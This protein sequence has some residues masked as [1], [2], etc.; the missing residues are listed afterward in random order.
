MPES[1]SRAPHLV[2]VLGG[3]GRATKERRT[4]RNHGESRAQHMESLWGKIRAA[5]KTSCQN[6]LNMSTRTGTW[7]QASQRTTMTGKTTQAVMKRSKT[8]EARKAV[9][10]DGMLGQQK[11]GCQAIKNR[12]TKTVN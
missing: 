7:D 5:T 3:D 12:V 1:K 2:L 4:G 10:I 6:G 9:M 8:V 11:T